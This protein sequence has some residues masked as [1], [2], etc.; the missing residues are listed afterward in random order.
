VTDRRRTKR[1]A[2]AD[3]PDETNFADVVGI[4]QHKSIEDAPVGR[5]GA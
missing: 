3:Q 4:L 1:A 5:I 2:Y